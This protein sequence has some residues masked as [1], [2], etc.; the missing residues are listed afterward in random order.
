MS[1]IS[2]LVLLQNPQEAN[3]GACGVAEEK[4]KK[5]QD[6]INNWRKD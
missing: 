6:N 3:T 4:S 1:P 2:F 5:L